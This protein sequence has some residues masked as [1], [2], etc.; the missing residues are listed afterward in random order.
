L[1]AYFDAV[2]QDVREILAQLGFRSLDEVVGRTDYLHQC[3]VPDHPKA[4]TINLDA[5][6]ARRDFENEKRL[7]VWPRNDRP[8]V[9]LDDTILLDVRDSLRTRIPIIR[10][11][12]VQ[13]INRSVGTKLSGEIAYLYGHRGL[14]AGTIELQFRGSAGQSFGAFLVR[15]VRL[16]L[17]GE[18]NDYVGKGLSGGEIIVVPPHGRVHV[19]ADVIIGNTVLYGATEGALFVRGR[20]GERF[21]VR[22]S[23]ALAVCEGVGD[24]GCEY[25]TNGTVV[26]LGSCGRN[27]GAGMT[28]GV[29]FVLDAAHDFRTRCNADYVAVSEVD[30]DADIRLL[31]GLISRH[32]EL[33]ESL[34]AREVLAGWAEYRSVFVKVTPR[35]GPP[36]EKSESLRTPGEMVREEAGAETMRG[37]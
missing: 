3:S 12:A 37:E 17:E 6:L 36:V 35:Q 24:H 15:G 31:R 21:C 23:G 32:F 28:G 34:R 30:T 4:N 25:M 2:A 10:R 13:N 9:P 5:L 16:V 29:A 1:I 26:V 20:A 22:N 7:R 14:P 19:P 18:A 27:F 8:D 11:Y 33:T